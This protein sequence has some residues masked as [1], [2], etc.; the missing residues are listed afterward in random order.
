MAVK[1]N[2]KDN[3]DP[4]YRKVTHTQ[5]TGIKK[6]GDKGPQSWLQKV[7][8]P[9]DKYFYKGNMGGQTVTDEFVESPAQANI[10][11]LIFGGVALLFV[12]L[13]LYILFTNDEIDGSGNEFI[14]YTLSISIL[15]L[16]FIIYYYFTMPKKEI[17]LNRMDSTIT[18]PGFMWKKNITMPFD[19]IKFSYTS[20]GPNFIGAYML[21][22]VRPDKAGST[23]GFPFPGIDCY[24]DL[25]YLTW[26]MDKN[27]PLPPAED[28]DAYREKDF[29]RRKKE[30]F[31]KPLYRSQIPT[32]EATPEQQA[33]RERIGK[34]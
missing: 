5:Y 8:V 13:S 24:Q 21:V 22:I 14:Y 34:W 2:S 7:I 17:I 11:P 30:K 20:G 27:R 31:K 19:K 9:L 15:I 1:N 29:E 10:A 6:I 26:Y 4:L 12:L 16:L 3:K 33:E 28:L 18:F 32:P 23:L 25:A